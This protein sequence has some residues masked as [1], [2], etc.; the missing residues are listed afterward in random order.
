MPTTPPNPAPTLERDPVCG[1]SV[2]A[3]TAK[4]IHAHAGKTYYFCCAACA[5]KFKAAPPK[6]LAATPARSLALV[7][8]GAA[9]AAPPAHPQLRTLGSTGLQR[10]APAT[11][12]AY[13]CPMCPEVHE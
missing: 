8:L 11:G 9:K 12:V 6:Y 10:Q 13:V 4:H 2:N 5:E 1:M 7:T 3:T